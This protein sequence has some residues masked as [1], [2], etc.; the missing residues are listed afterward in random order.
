LTVIEAES[1]SI[2]F[3]ESLLIKIKQNDGT[4]L[5]VA[6]IYRSPNSSVDNDSLLIKFID[7]VCKFG[8]VEDC[9]G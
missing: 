3:E 1:K 6:V 9:I 4:Y 8:R 7:E 5:F 2:H